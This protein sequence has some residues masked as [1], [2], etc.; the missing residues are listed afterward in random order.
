ML[1]TWFSSALWPFSTLG[2]P[3]ETPDFARYY[4]TS[5]LITGF[6]IIF[7]WVARM[8]MMGLEFTGEVPF[9]ATSTSRRWCAT[10]FGKKMTKSRG[11]VVDPL[12]LMERYGTDAVRFTLAQLGRAGPRPDPVATIASPRRAHSPTRSGTRRASC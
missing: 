8:M 11:N 3:E 1:D 7:F 6:D 10:Q 5:L 4:P 2:W 12:E 9:Q